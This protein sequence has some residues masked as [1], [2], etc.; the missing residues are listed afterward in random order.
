M[1]KIFA[2]RGTDEKILISCPDYQV[3]RVVQILKDT[4][5]HDW[6]YVDKIQ[7]GEFLRYNDG[8]EYLGYHGREE[9]YSSIETIIRKA[10]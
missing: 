3:M 7:S 5:G 10:K 9:R 4:Y 1:I 2:K 6:V 8:I